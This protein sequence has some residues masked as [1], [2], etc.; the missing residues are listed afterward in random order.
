MKHA[1]THSKRL[2]K[3]FY[4][5]KYAAQTVLFQAATELHYAMI[6]AQM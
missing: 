6:C 3:T 4:M 2:A 5:N 1:L